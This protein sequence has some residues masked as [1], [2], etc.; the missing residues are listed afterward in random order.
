M[1]PNDDKADPFILKPISSKDIFSNLTSIGVR[2]TLSDCAHDWEHDYYSLMYAWLIRY[3]NPIINHMHNLTVI[4]IP[5]KVKYGDT[6][7]YRGFKMNLV[8]SHDW[9]SFKTDLIGDLDSCLLCTT[10]LIQV[11]VS[12]ITWYPIRMWMGQKLPYPVLLRP[13]KQAWHKSGSDT[14]KKW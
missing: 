3:F 14:L 9:E 2:S 1:G 4:W 11:H 12:H 13:L 7:L 5:F 6:S 10:F 8:F